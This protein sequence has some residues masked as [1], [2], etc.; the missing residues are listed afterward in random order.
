MALAWVASP[1]SPTGAGVLHLPEPRS[2]H[3]RSRRTSRGEEDL[4]LP[5]RPFH[6]PCSSV[7]SRC[8]PPSGP[9]PH[10]PELWSPAFSPSF[11]SPAFLSEP[12]ET[13]P[14]DRAVPQTCRANGGLRKEDFLLPQ[15]LLLLSP[16]L[17]PSHP[18]VPLKPPP[19]STY[20]HLM[21]KATAFFFLY[22]FIECLLYA[23][24]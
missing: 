24:C 16:L 10:V 21:V 5:P 12:A 1:R 19:L 8:P 3:Q 2:L 23:G 18:T 15:L 22:S 17:S 4:R 6:R 13:L 9:T 20:F 11:P 14:E 7:L